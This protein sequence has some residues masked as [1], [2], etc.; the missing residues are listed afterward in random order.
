[1]TYYLWKGKESEVAAR[2]EYLKQVF[3][4]H[5]IRCADVGDFVCLRSFPF[6]E[7]G[8]CFVTGH[9]THA[10]SLLSKGLQEETIVLNCCFPKQF[11]EFTTKHRIYF[12][13]VDERG[14][15]R[16]R[17]AS[18]FATGFDILDSEL[19][20]LYSDKD[21]VMDKIRDAYTLI[22]GRK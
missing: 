11:I 2:V 15:A 20:L 22:G 19:S 9:N 14:L 13:K 18:E 12:C 7:D 8:V 1:M 17:R 21:D 3:H 5:F 4:T 10:H 6:K 16:F